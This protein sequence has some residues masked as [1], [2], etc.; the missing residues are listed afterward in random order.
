MEEAGDVDDFGE[1]ADFGEGRLKG[2]FGD[3]VGD[4]DEFYYTI[5]NADLDD[6][7]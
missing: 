5:L 3:F 4:D 7:L 2:A 1:L 6:G